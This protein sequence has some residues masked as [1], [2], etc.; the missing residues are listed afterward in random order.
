MTVEV[1][2]FFNYRSPYCYLASKTMWQ[3]EDHHPGR[4]VFKP[5]GGWSGR[6]PPERVKHKL[7]ITR[8]DVRRW[9]KRMKIP[10][11][12]PPV[13]TDPTKAAMGATLA[14]EHGRIRDYTVAVMD[15][16]WAEGK[17]I[18][19]PEVLLEVARSIGLDANAF[20]TA[21][22]SPERQAM[23]DT[24]AE[25]AKEKGIFGVPTFLIGEEIFWGQDRIDFVV[26]HIDELTKR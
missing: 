5:L 9:T 17:D 22:E 20:T 1:L 14:I 24:N 15:K 2:T 10:F 3:I 13:T 6:S 12:P 11:V 18:G 4:L 8:Q 23:L 25:L 16:E 7:P 21:L 26:E 19:Q